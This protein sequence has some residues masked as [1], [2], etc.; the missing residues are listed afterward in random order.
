MI[1]AEFLIRDLPDPG[2][3]RRFLAELSEK[4]ES[5]SKKLLA[6]DALLS[7]V[8]LLVSYSPLI[9]ATLLQHP[10]Y[11]A[12]L[13]RERLNASV[14]E[15]PE[16]LESL[17][18]FSLTNSQIEPHVALSRF[19]RR[20]LIRVFLRDIRRLAT[21][22]EITEEISNLADTI[23]EH[24]LRLA[25]QELDNRFGQPQTSDEK[26][27]SVRAEFCIVSL[28][29]LGSKE[30]NYSS[31]IDLLFIYSDEGNTS[32]IGTAGAVTNGEYFSKLSETIVKLVG[33]QGGEGA[34][35]RVDMRLRPRGRVAPLAVSLADAVRYYRKEAAAWERQVLIRSRASAGSIEVFKSFYS[36]VEMCV[37]NENE[38]VEN[39]LANVKASKYKI[40]L[41]H[42]T[43]NG[44]NVK[45]G[46]GGIREIEFI[47]QALELAYGGRDRWLRCSHTLICLSRLADRGHIQKAELTELFEAYTF[48]RSTEH[49]LQMENGLQTH[50]VPTDRSRRRLLAAKLGLGNTASFDTA[51][52]SHVGNVNRAFLRVF[53]T[54]MVDEGL[55]ERAVSEPES[56]PTVHAAPAHFDIEG[57]TS[58]SQRAKEMLSGNPKLIDT[59]ENIEGGLPNRDHS[60]I[61]TNAIRDHSDFRVAIGVLRQEWTRLLFEIIVFDVFEK[62]SLAEC[63]GAQTKLAEAS[64]A[65]AIVLTKRELERRYDL[66]IDHLP[67]AVLGLGKLGGGGM[68]Y[69][70]DLDLVMVYEAD[71]IEEVNDSELY[72]RAVEIFTNVLSSITRDGSLYRVDLRLRPYGGK[73]PVAIAKSAFSEYMCSSAAIWEMLAFVK[74][75]AV[76]G[77]VKLATQ[78]AKEVREIIHSRAKE[79]DIAEL[80]S[81]TRSVR[82]RLEKQK[83][84]TLRT[85]DI[86]IKYGAGGLLDVY[87][88]LRFLQLQHNIPDNETDRSTSATINRLLARPEL[89]GSGE[90]ANAL[91]ILHEGHAFLS[92]LEHNIRLTVGRTT[93]FPTANRHALGVIARRMG[94]PSTRQ[95]LDQL[96]LHRLA[97]RSAFESIV[98]S[99]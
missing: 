34:A 95:I 44:F 69:D 8:L 28:G 9:A 3:A 64:I 39:A 32:G 89:G 20:E 50:T 70:S 73:G 53:E 7:D 76:G 78:V 21:I 93:R 57:L 91:T 68:D 46:V 18:R 31:D 5:A 22:A 30:L 99:E 51:I 80:A 10:E 86:D 96:N 6:N 67:L 25:R 13:D 26:G 17:A 2:S 54:R 79:T 74:L 38:T 55:P 97:I 83:T 23:L 90:I 87:F 56:I 16:L 84:G 12:W 77:E 61:L 62:I 43:R 59:I 98:G 1:D 47:A 35:Y 60:G 45:L 92:T 27:R 58:N 52:E 72:S 15:T 24:A 41:Q 14:R 36:Q 42:R 29:K 81:E 94:L 37:F 4:N 49:I 65:A 63:K 33:R 85:K 11:L 71:V 48:L 40:D 75:R 88:A 66:L 82:D 19:R